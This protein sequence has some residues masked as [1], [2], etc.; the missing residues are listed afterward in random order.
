MADAPLA[1]T[2]DA[3]GFGLTVT[4]ES[5]RRASARVRGYVGQSALPASSMTQAR[6]PLIQLPDR[7]VVSVTTVTIDGVALDTSEWALTGDLLEVPGRTEWV[8]VT[9]QSGKALPDPQLEA[10]C[11]IAARLT[12][13]ATGA[14]SPQDMGVQQQTAG[15]FSMTFGWDSYRALSDLTTGEKATLDRVFASSS[16]RLPRLIVTGY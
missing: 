9:Y 8:A 14:A 12:T 2:A 1:T 7:P 16:R 15:S 6:G 5:L 4:D 11:T 13:I 10:V 3:A